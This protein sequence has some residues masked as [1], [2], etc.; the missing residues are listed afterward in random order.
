MS[1]PDENPG[2]GALKDKL[3]ARQM[4]RRILQLLDQNASA[5]AR[6]A[7]VVKVEGLLERPRC[8]GGFVWPLPGARNLTVR[9]LKLLLLNNRL[10]LSSV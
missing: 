2:E 10:V 7:H 3:A 9:V 5:V 8:D 4:R 1:L 6:Q